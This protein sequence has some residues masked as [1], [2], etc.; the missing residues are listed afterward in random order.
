MLRENTFFKIEKKL[1]KLSIISKRF[2]KY[3]NKYEN[4][5]KIENIVYY[6]YGSIS[7]NYENLFLLF[8]K[9]EMF[10]SYILGKLIKNVGGNEFLPRKLKLVKNLKMI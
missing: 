7:I 4:I 2:T 9:N 1:H 6:S 8:K 3:I 10:C 5:W